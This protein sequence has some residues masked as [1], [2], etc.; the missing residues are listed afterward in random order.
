MTEIDCRYQLVST[1]ERFLGA[2]K[3][4][5]KHKQLIDAYNKI[6]PLP[7]G[8]KMTYNEAWCAATVSAI[9]YW[10][11]MLDIIPAECS[12]SKMIAKLRKRGEWCEDDKYVPSVGDLIFYDWQDGADYANT[13][14]RGNPD[15]VGIVERCNGKTITV[16]EGNKSG[17][18]GR[19]ALAVNGRYIR[20]Y[21]LPDYK[22]FAAKKN[23]TDSSFSI[24]DVVEFTGNT[25]YYSCNS[26]GAKPCKGG[27]CRITN[28]VKGAKHP[29]H[30]VHIGAG[31]TVFG[32][33]DLKDIK[34]G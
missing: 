12:C 9:A 34:K 20:G 26:T 17:K 16:I 23:K 27:T 11:D 30:L 3:G 31:C 10:C 2:S 13:N 24:G 19:R 14:N 7:R 32:W 1:A 15:H 22:G 6:T 33:C 25:H 29:Y 8:H 4:S 21:G 5:T 28:F 18:V